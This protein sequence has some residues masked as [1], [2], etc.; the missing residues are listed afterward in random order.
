[1]RMCMCQ[2]KP[3][4]VPEIEYD[5][6]VE[7][8]TLAYQAQHQYIE[9]LR[10]SMDEENL[11]NTML[12]SRFVSMPHVDDFVQEG[13]DQAKF[14]PIFDDSSFSYL[15]THGTDAL[16]TLTKNQGNAWCS[17]I[18]HFIVRHLI[19]AA[20]IYANTISYY[21]MY[22]PSVH[23]WPYSPLTYFHFKKDQCFDMLKE[24][25][26]FLFSGGMPLCVASKEGFVSQLLRSNFYLIIQ[27]FEWGLISNATRLIQF[28]NFFYLSRT[29][30]FEY[31]LTVCMGLH[32]RLGEHCVFYELQDDLLQRICTLVFQ[33]YSDAVAQQIF[34]ND[35]QWLF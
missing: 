34:E 7:F 30:Y 1:M 8:V 12:Q 11:N 14:V 23:Q 19:R 13:P 32:T 16:L 28:P 2:Y 21:S 17:H 18:N 29:E 22:G 15:Q 4:K 31:I 35:E 25:V 9:I 20:K 5:N 26:H 6:R 24:E 3:M 27:Y 10:Q 33:S